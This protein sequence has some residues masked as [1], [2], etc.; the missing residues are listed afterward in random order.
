M[1]RAFGLPAGREDERVVSRALSAARGVFSRCRGG[2]TAAHPGSGFPRV[3]GKAPE[4]TPKIPPGIVARAMK[5][6]LII[7]NEAHSSWSFQPWILMRHFGVAWPKKIYPRGNV[8][9]FAVRQMSC[10]AR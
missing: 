2:R 1:G 3:S 6:I 10:P 4:S 9:L 8:A 5:P 7:A